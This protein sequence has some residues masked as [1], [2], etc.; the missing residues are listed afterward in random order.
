[1]KH[2]IYLG[3][4]SN[5]GDKV[6]FLAAAIR[7]IADFDMT[8]VD[9]VSDIY[10]TEPVG[11]VVQ[12]D[13]LNLAVSVR[14][15]LTVEEFHAKMKWLEQEIGRKESERWGP[16]EIDIDLLFFDAVIMETEKL[17]IPHRE[18]VNRKFVLQPLADIAPMMIH[19]E[20]HKSIEELNNET[21]DCHRVVR[22][23]MH[24]ATLFALINDS[25]TNPT[26]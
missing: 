12:D 13:F 8:V 25:I 3:L 16:R 19:P 15:D 1:M 5:V 6:E 20:E 18:L 26:I 14:T 10:Q 21:T 17:R 24:T 23:D 7:G 11:T 4:G 9:A 22:S 2:A